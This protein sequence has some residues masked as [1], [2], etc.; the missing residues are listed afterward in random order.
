MTFDGIPTTKPDRRE[1][2]R[3]WYLR[4]K[5]RKAAQVKA[6]R[7]VNKDRLAAA[8]KKWQEAHPE[9]VR[10]RQKRYRAKRGKAWCSLQNKAY[11]I[12]NRKTLNEYKARLRAHNPEPKRE[13]SRK[14]YQRNKG[15]FFAAVLKRNAIKA[16]VT[17]NAEGIA[18]WMAAVRAKP[19]AACYY[20]HKR[21]STKT[22]HFD[23]IL[24]L[25]KGGAHSI[26]NLCVSC[27]HCNLTKGPKAI[28]EW[29]TI[30]QQIMEF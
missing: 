6:Y 25:S 24:A 5:E 18:Q 1:Y 8:N 16:G 20:C 23:H 29:M 13:Y 28:Q 14:Y 12:K 10:L 19:S 15:A 11:R 7:L 30:G 4:N 22:V 17:V 9:N 2:H 21:V 3:Q 27:A 26:E